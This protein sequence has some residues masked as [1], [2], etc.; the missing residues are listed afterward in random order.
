MERRFAWS[1]VVAMSCGRSAEPAGPVPAPTPTPT[2][3][4]ADAGPAPRAVGPR[5]LVGETCLPPEFGRSH[6]FP[7]FAGGDLA[8]TA[9]VSAARAPLAEAPQRFQV[10]GSRGVRHGHILTD[11]NGVPDDPRGFVGESY[12]EG[13]GGPCTYPLPDHVRVTD[14][15]CGAAGNCGI[16]VAIRGDLAHPTTRPAI[17]VGQ[18]CVVD[19][20]LIG[21][22]DGDGAAESFPLEGF[23][24]PG[25]VE[26]VAHRGA[27]CP[28]P[29][30]S[31]YRM[32]L[33]ADVLDVLGAAD[34]DRDGHLELL[35]AYTAA[36]GQRTVAIYTPASG[37]IR[38]ER[39]AAVVR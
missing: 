8:W 22:L 1:V 21:D 7:L 38:L 18:V 15:G 12:Y 27:P 2:P 26:G 13:G 36:G 20:N 3:A 28:H 9:E 35:V 29:R 10:L 4:A 24:G 6:L 14:V 17:A 39:R 11:V 19:A 5:Y 25:D 34:L 23:R 30:F 32:R 37:P 33:G 16:S 31:W